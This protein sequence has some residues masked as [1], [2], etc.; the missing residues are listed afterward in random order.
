[1]CIEIILHDDVQEYVALEILYGYNN[2]Y[3]LD[4][5]F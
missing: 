1:M 2:T 3:V 4:V 5:I